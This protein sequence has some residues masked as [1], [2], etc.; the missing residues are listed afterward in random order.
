M[1]RIF[2]VLIRVTTLGKYGEQIKTEYRY[3][4]S[5]DSEKAALTKGWRI[6]TEEF[7]SAEDHD[8]NIVYGSG[9]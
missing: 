4:V 6:A 2:T 8:V 1:T 9:S 3:P 7:E 5:A